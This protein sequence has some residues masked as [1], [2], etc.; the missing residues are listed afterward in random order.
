MS[1]HLLNPDEPTLV[2]PDIHNDID[3][4]EKILDE[5]KDIRQKVSLGDWFDSF[6]EGPFQVIKTAHAYRRFVRDENNTVLFGNHD[7]QYAYPNIMGL[8]C[9]GFS[10]EKQDTLQ[11][12][13]TREVW[14][15]V[16]FH[17]RIGKWILTHAGIHPNFANAI[18]GLSDPQYLIDYEASVRSFLDRG[19]MHCWVGAG[20]SRGGPYPFGGVTWL[21]FREFEPVSGVNQLVGH[22]HSR[23]GEVRQKVHDDGTS[24]NYCIDTGLKHVAVIENQKIKVY[25]KATFD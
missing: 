14:E 22:T 2:I 11:N 24:I 20:R 1:L 23:Y 8:K 16:L 13:I 18:T 7:I 3:T 10:M 21:D 25:S 4:L 5:Y 12:M 9:S 15:K 19:D 17:V 6:N